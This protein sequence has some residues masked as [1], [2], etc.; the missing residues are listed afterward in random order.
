M[1]L[2]DS[3]VTGRLT[4]G[5]R[6]NTQ[7]Q[8]P[9]KKWMVI[10]ECPWNVFACISTALQSVCQLFCEELDCIFKR[11]R[12]KTSAIV[13]KRDSSKNKCAAVAAKDTVQ[14]PSSV[15]QNS[16]SEAQ[17][18][19]KPVR[20]CPGPCRHKLAPRESYRDWGGW[21]NDCLLSWWPRSPSQDNLSH[22][23]LAIAGLLV[24]DVAPNCLFITMELIAA[25]TSGLVPGRSRS[26]VSQHWGQ[27][28]L[29]YFMFYL[30]PS[31]LEKC[32]MA[33]STEVNCS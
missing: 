9:E 18:A 22:F 1:S 16:F 12:R 7:P 3:Q 15:W 13:Q 32:K 14:T 20:S 24:L 19:F 10:I 27:E 23:K 2:E 21:S 29:F 5:F 30:F 6:Q 31:S 25:P 11:S 33:S 8:N 4:F 17:G 28:P 26:Q